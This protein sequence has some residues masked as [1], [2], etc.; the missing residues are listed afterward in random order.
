[1]G[2]TCIYLTTKIQLLIINRALSQR[3]KSG[4]GNGD[5]IIPLLSP[6]A[7]PS[8]PIPFVLPGGSS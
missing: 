6:P 5:G 7:H 8:L 1:M 2:C 3:A 4:N